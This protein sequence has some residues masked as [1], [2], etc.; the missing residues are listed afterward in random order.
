METVV[1]YMC[2]FGL[3]LNLRL[4]EHLKHQTCKC[5]GFTA[6]KKS[7]QILRSA[8]GSELIPAVKPEQTLISKLVSAWG[9]SNNLIYVKPVKPCSLQTIFMLLHKATRL[10]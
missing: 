4:L 2:Q 7:V 10:K 6:Y 1:S 3:S 5:D 9:K 8:A